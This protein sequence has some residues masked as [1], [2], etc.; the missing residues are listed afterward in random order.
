MIKVKLT[1][2]GK[3]HDKHAKEWVEHYQKLIKQHCDLEIK[4]IK[5]EKLDKGKNEAEVLRREGERIIDVVKT[6]D[7]LVI[8]DRFGKKLKSKHFAKF[9]D[10]YCSRSNV[11]LHFVIGGTI[12]ISD[13][14]QKFAD[15][16]LSLSDMTF[17]HQMAVVVFIEQLYRAISI[18][19]GLP[20]HK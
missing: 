10:E 8:L 9:M 12:G 19:K 17:S 4:F 1:T 18:I 14:I 5:E 16:R 20:Y 2:V 6:G 7:Y 3:L 11:T 13:Q 15:M